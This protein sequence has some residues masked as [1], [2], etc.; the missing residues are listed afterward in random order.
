M[1]HDNRDRDLN[2]L[3][4]YAFSLQVLPRTHFNTVYAC[5]AFRFLF[6]C[7]AYFFP[8]LVECSWK[9]LLIKTLIDN[10]A[11]AII[12]IRPKERKKIKKR[13]LE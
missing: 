7:F 10:G 3:F 4:T 1:V 5:F 2:K 12:N 9:T 11:I 8:S 13:Q 6:K